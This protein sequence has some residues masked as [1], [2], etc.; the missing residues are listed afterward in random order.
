MRRQPSY[1]LA[2]GAIGGGLSASGASVR[3]I[4]GDIRFAEALAQMGAVIEMGDNWIEASTDGRPP[5]ISPRLQPH[6]RCRDD[7]G[8]VALFAAGP[9]TLTNI[10]S[11]RVKGNRSHRGHGE[12]APQAGRRGRGGAGPYP[13]VAPEELHVAAG[14]HRHLR[15]PSHRHVLLAGCL[16]HALRINDPK[17]VAKTFPDYFER[18]STVTR[19]VPVIAID[20]PSASGRDGRRPC[21]GIAWLALP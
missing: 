10:A 21:R 13:R 20:G 4:Q 19:P 7:A 17:C 11:W 3:P 2:L 18:L 15:R 9:T 1:F 5:G 6:S 16:R 12:G 14:R 8:D